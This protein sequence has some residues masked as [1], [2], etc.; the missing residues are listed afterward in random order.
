MG[1]DFAVRE[2]IHARE[3]HYENND[4]TLLDGFAINYPKE[5]HYP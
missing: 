2:K 4:W 3:A 1:T 5:T